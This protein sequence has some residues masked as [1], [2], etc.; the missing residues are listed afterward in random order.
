MR[1]GLLYDVGHDDVPH[2]D[3]SPPVVPAGGAEN[4]ASISARRR[5]FSRIESPTLPEVD[6]K[7]TEG[8]YAKGR[9][10]SPPALC[11][12]GLVRW[13]I[14][15]KSPGSVTGRLRAKAASAR[16]WSPVRFTS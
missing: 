2:G 12:S 10:T 14:D 5:V 1:Q 8:G 16:S 15:P 11:R 4:S 3:D 9:S 6:E 13:Q 7:R